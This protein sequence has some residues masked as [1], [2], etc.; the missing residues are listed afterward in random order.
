MR[1]RK[2]FSTM[3]LALPAHGRGMS[4]RGELRWLSVLVLGGAACAPRI[5][6][7]D[8]QAQGGAAGDMNP[9][10]GGGA[11]VGNDSGG[12]AGSAAASGGSAGTD[13]LPRP[14]GGGSSGSGGS[15]GGT[16]SGAGSSP[17]FPATN[18]LN[19]SE[20]GAIQENQFAI[21][22]GWYSFDDCA[23]ATAVGLP[24]T[25]RDAEHVGPDELTGWW[26]EST[27][28]VCARGVAPRV[29]T[30]AHADA[31]ALQWGLGVGFT[32][33]EGSESDPPSYDAP[34]HGILGFVFDVTGTTQSG[35]L[36]FNLVTAETLSEP[37]HIE[38]QIP[39][40][41]R[42]VYLDEVAQGPWITNPVPFTPN[43]LHSVQFHVATGEIDTT[44]FDF[45]VRNLR[46]LLAR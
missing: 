24:C 36:R 8:E 12:S 1:D 19:W 23:E 6:L 30:A 26:I 15:T 22:G 43:A 38:L 18:L 4:Q 11:S 34:A 20:Q 33:D 40:Q 31:Y 16:G 37:H 17:S 25:E 27:T 28:E 5:D 39:V 45:C 9:P 44:S 7:L 13:G 14:G 3:G 41:N 32:L 2:R 42:V 10:S 21:L 35:L 29:D 46:V